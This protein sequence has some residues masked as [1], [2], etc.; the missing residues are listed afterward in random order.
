MLL[1]SQ[2]ESIVR[3]TLAEERGDHDFVFVSGKQKM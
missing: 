1:P 3:N 2:F